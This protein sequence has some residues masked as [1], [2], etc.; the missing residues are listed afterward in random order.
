MTECA[1]C[2]DPAELGRLCRVC[3]LFADLFAP[4]NR[5]VSNEPDPD[6]FWDNDLADACA[7][8][9]AVR[10]SDIPGIVAVAK[11]MN[12]QQV[13]LTLSKM[14]AEACP[15]RMTP[16]RFRAWAARVVDNP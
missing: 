9:N 6:L 16:E 1:M 2:G 15:E 3:G 10:G 8:V 4:I 7:L 14:L 13:A 12:A 5:G 11:H